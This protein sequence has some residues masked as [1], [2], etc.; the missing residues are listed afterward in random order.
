MPRVGSV[1]GACEECCECPQ[2]M[3]DFWPNIS[4]VCRSLTGTARLYGYSGYDDGSYDPGDPAAWVGQGRKWRERQLEGEERHV[5]TANFDACGNNY[6]DFTFIWTGTAERDASGVV[7]WAQQE[8]FGWEVFTCTPQPSSFSDVEDYNF[9]LSATGSCNPTDG[10]PRFVDTLTVRTITFCRD[11]TVYDPAPA[12]T[13]TM[14]L[15]SEGRFYDALLDDLLLEPEN[16]PEWD[17]PVEGV[18]CVAFVS[19]QSLTTPRSTSPITRTGRGVALNVTVS[20]APETS[21]TVY[22]VYEITAAD[23]TVRGGREAVEV[24]TDE[25]GLVEFTYPVPDPG[26]DETSRVVSVES[27]S[28]QFRF[29]LPRVGVADCYR[30]IWAERVYDPEGGMS[31]VSIPVSDGGSGYTEPPVITLPPP[32][33]AEEDGGIQA[34]AV[35]VLT[36][37]VLTGITLTEAGAGYLA[38]AGGRW[39]STV[40]VGIA[41]PAGEGGVQAV[42]GC[43]VL[44]G[45]TAREWQWTGTPPEGYDRADPATWPTSEAFTVDLEEGEV[46]SLACVRAE[47][48]GC[49]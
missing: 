43:P 31:F 48:G 45:D 32:D 25:E 19:S 8:F 7:A 23:D 9:P 26:L 11:A 33:I 30:I 22:F 6:P 21:Y 27:D 44:S 12:G 18:E 39:A 20:G 1:V 40:P 38:G 41:P 28:Y 35:G 47:C 36:E 34:E 2:P 24:S 37:G 49:A 10:F 13:L 29:P 42:A 17:A 4:F 5:S 3:V 46:W 14:T 16:R 15:L